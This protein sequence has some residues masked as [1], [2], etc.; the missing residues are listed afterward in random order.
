MNEKYYN[1]PKEK[2]QRILNAG[3]RVFSQNSY[4]RSPMREIADEAGISKSLLF[5]YFLN[6]KELY[7]FLWDEGAR[8]TIEYLEKCGCYKKLGLFDQ[9]E[10]GMYAKLQIMK[11]YPDMAAFTIK[12]FYEKDSEVCEEIQKSYQ[13]YF[14]M[15]TEKSLVGLN[16]DDFMPG[17]DL[18][19]M[20]KDMYWAGGGYLW[21]VMQRGAINAEQLE[22]DFAKLIDFWKKIYIKRGSS[23]GNNQ[24]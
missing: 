10:R 13:K 15:K 24:N 3:Y 19:M 1:L 11:I 14:N 17:L 23:D 21:E 2:Q 18:E 9:M 12:A 8:I 4:K 5:H 22:Q 20:Y 16:P 7:M 6:K